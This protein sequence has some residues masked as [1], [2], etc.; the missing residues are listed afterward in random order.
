MTWFSLKPRFYV[1]I[2]AESAQLQHIRVRGMCVLM[3]T[4]WNRNLCK[5]LRRSRLAAQQRFNIFHKSIFFFKECSF[6]ASNC[7]WASS[8]SLPTCP[9]LQGELAQDK[10]SWNEASPSGLPAVTWKVLNKASLLESLKAKRA[11]RG[12][13]EAAESSL[14]AERGHTHTHLL[15]CYCFL[16]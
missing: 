9:T 4:V 1:D 2:A 5:Q 15:N 12:T 13:N 6:V 14:L 10:G 16:L 7:L 3:P 8:L 11:G